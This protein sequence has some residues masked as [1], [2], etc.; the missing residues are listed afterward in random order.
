MEWQLSGGKIYNELA[1]GETLNR[2]LM[3]NAN[4]RVI[5]STE[6]VCRKKSNIFS[7][8]AND[9]TQDIPIFN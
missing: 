3:L 1:W 4:V 7:F 6:H 8:D 2:S 9:L 5:I